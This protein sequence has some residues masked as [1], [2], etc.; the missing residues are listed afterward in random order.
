MQAYVLDEN[1]LGEWL[2]DAHEGRP[3]FPPIADGIALLTYT[4]GT[5]GVPK[6]VAITN[7]ALVQWF[8][9]AES[10]PDTAWRSSD[11]G[12]MVMPNFHLA[13]TWVSLP[14]LMHGA[15][16]V[17]LPAFEPDTFL[18]AVSE[19]GVTRTCLVPTAIE[20]VV[21]ALHNYPADLTSLRSVM[22]AGSPIASHTLRSV[23]SA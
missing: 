9:A 1:S 22:Y 21:Q 2:S 10:D 14:A 17:V 3:R 8:R 23:R 20:A 16:L 13:G 6:G 18:S 12:L 15:T 4:S 7:G 5:T 19:Y 11:V